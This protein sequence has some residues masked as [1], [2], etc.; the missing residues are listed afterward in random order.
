MS[1]YR[2]GTHHGVTICR[3]GDGHHCG[4]PEH[5]CE[6]GHLVAVIVNDDWEL[7]E[8]ICGLLN[9]DEVVYCPTCDLRMYRGTR[10]PHPLV[11]SARPISPQSAQDASEVVR[12]GVSD[13]E[14]LESAYPTIEHRPQTPGGDGLGYGPCTGCGELWP[15]TAFRAVS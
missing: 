1:T 8:R 9:G 15:C 14:S 4:R 5:D 3:E 2:A 10:H 6:R 12:S 11:P 7:A 13:S